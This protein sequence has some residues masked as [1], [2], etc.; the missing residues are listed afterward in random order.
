M[1][2]PQNNF[3]GQQHCLI[4]ADSIGK[5][6]EFDGTHLVVCRQHRAGISLGDV[7]L[8][9]QAAG[10]ALP[11]EQAPQEEGGGGH[12]DQGPHARVCLAAM[13]S[14]TF[15]TGICRKSQLYSFVITGDANHQLYV[16]L[17]NV[18]TFGTAGKFPD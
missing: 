16:S 18:A 13:L 10:G 5:H 3:R 6:D 17:V 12:H 2:L 4:T 15:S 8:P 1:L 11:A 7:L 9:G 14:S